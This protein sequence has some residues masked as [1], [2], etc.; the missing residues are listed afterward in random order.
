MTKLIQ[1]ADLD[2]KLNNHTGQIQASVEAIATL[3]ARMEAEGTWPTTSQL[4]ALR[5]AADD[6]LQLHTRLQATRDARFKRP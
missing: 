3:A 2:A 6:L 5:H 4:M 1:E